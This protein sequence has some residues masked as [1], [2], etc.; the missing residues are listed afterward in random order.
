MTEDGRDAY[1][2]INVHASAICSAA[3]SAWSPPAIGGLAGA[4]QKPASMPAKVVDRLIARDHAR[5][6]ERAKLL[7]ETRGEGRPAEP[8]GNFLSRWK[9]AHADINLALEKALARTGA[10]HASAEL[11]AVA[12][13]LVE[14]EREAA[15][16]AFFLPAYDTRQVGLAIQAAKQRLEAAR[17]AACTGHRPVGDADSAARVVA[18]QLGASEQ[19]AKDAHGLPTGTGAQQQGDDCLAARRGGVLNT[20]SAVRG[21]ADCTIV[22]TA[23]QLAGGTFAAEGLDCCTLWLA[24]PLAALRLAGLRGCRVFAGPVAGATFVDDAAGCTL[25]LASRQVR[26]HRVNDCAA[27]LRVASHPILEHCSGM[28]VAPCA[29][30]YPGSAQHLAAAALGVDSG[31][32]RDVRDFCWLRATP[33]PNWR[34]IPEEQRERLPSYPAEA[35][36]SASA[37]GPVA[38]NLE[39]LA[40]REPVKKAQMSAATVKTQPSSPSTPVRQLGADEWRARGKL[41]PYPP[42]PPACSTVFGGGMAATTREADERHSAP[43]IVPM[44]HGAPAPA[45][46]VGALAYNPRAVKAA[47]AAAGGNAA[48]T[49]FAHVFCDDSIGVLYVNDNVGRLDL[50]PGMLGLPNG[51]GGRALDTWWATHRLAGFFL[52]MVAGSSKRQLAYVFWG[53]NRL[54][55]VFQQLVIA[56]LAVSTVTTL[57]AAAK[58]PDLVWLASALF[59]GVAVVRS[60]AM[61]WV[62]SKHAGRLDDVEATLA[63]YRGCG[64]SPLAELCAA[65]L[66]MLDRLAVGVALGHLAQYEPPGSDPAQVAA[67][68]LYTA[69]SLSSDHPDEPLDCSLPQYAFCRGEKQLLRICMHSATSAGAA[70]ALQGA[71]TGLLALANLCADDPGEAV[72]EAI[73]AAHKLVAATFVAGASHSFDRILFLEGCDVGHLMQGVGRKG[74]T[75][76]FQNL[77][78]LAWAVTL[79]DALTLAAPWIEA[80]PIFTFVSEQVSHEAAHALLGAEKLLARLIR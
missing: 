16:A 4:A 2:H 1:V 47:Y 50:P 26:L 29:L 65:E 32:W 73:N 67:L 10:A 54:G 8:A 5:M 77:C 19:P 62:L 75:S 80:S 6:A 27:Y 61:W 41:P 49:C 69:G 22:R 63:A 68:Q 79:A 40:P 37:G 17:G 12:R 46:K 70:L 74:L 21:L 25:A 23:A 72:S 20:G 38:Q 43:R 60:M 52:P 48:G 11:Y 57:E 59:F 64:D 39:A 3:G 78:L 35:H 44:W 51:L 66:P 33:S 14:A 76:L 7:E 55:L 36:L 9:Q 45:T 56:S 30:E 31:L 34:V 28:S 18:G 13:R 24:G 42:P 15:Q 53:I 58:W 71:A